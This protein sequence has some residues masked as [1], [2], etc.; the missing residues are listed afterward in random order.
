MISGSQYF[1]ENDVMPIEIK[2]NK[3]L[4]SCNFLTVYECNEW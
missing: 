2:N 4:I 1:V 3:I